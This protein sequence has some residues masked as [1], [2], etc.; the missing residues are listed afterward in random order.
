[1]LNVYAVKSSTDGATS[2]ISFIVSLVLL[3]VYAI[4]MGFILFY[5]F[6]LRKIPMYKMRRNIIFRMIYDDFKLKGGSRFS[7]LFFL[8]FFLKRV[9][10]A[11]VL[12]FLSNTN[13][14]PLDL[15]VFIVTIVPMIYFSYAMPFKFIGINALLCLNEFSE[16]VVGVVL[17]HY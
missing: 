6:G 5:V 17:L 14:I 15:F 12:V 16:T 8:F 13:I 4:G 3:I 1:L 2:S 7:L 9:V 10:Y 11:I